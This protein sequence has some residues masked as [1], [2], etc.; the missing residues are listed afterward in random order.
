MLLIGASTFGVALLPTYSAVGVWAP[1]LLVILRLIQGFA[2]GGEIAGASA[3]IIEHSPFG[4]RG[5]YG[6]F[7]LQG[8]QAGQIVAAA[9]F[10]PLSA[11][12]PKEAFETWGWRIPFL[13]SAVVVY[14]GY[15]IRKNVDETPAFQEEAE[16]GEVPQAPIVM[17]VKENGVDMFRVFCMALMN[18]IPTAVTTFGATFATNAGYGVGLTTTNYLWISV[19]GNVVAVILIPFVGNLTDRIGRRPGDH[20]RLP[21]IGHPG[22]PVPVLRRRSQLRRWRSC[23]PS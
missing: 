17:A 19:S 23:S 1:I 10:L 14:A 8:V 4:R 21:R 2:V 20:R 6:S 12:M 11:F 3:M 9:I 16:H 15:Q 18:A 5:Y 13:L 7:T 22:V